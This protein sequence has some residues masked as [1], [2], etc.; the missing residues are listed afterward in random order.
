MKRIFVGMWAINAILIAFVVV[1]QGWLGAVALAQERVQYVDGNSPPSMQIL[2]E[3]PSPKYGDVL[4][5]DA[6]SNLSLASM[7]L[8]GPLQ[9]H[10]GQR[11]VLSIP[12]DGPILI[13]GKP[14]SDRDVVRALRVWAGGVQ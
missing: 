10:N 3:S 2:G 14:A 12:K 13:D 8:Q 9:F 11:A 4:T 6:S 5:V 7:K 1:V